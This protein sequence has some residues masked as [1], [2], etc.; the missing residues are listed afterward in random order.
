MQLRGIHHLTAVTGRA[1]VNHDFYTRVM[2]MRLVKKTVNQDDVSAY[3]LFYADGVAQPG[4]DLTFFDWPVGPERRGTNSIVRTALRVA[5]AAALEYWAAR[6]DQLGVRHDPIAAVDGR[7][8]LAFEDT[9]GQRLALVVDG[10]QGPAFAW[11]RTEVP[12]AQQIRGLGPIIISVPRLPPSERF[13]TDILNMR[14][15]RAYAA[16]D[17]AAITTHVFEMDQGGPSAEL[18]VR[19]EPGLRPAQPGAGGVHHVAFRVRDDEYAAWVARYEQLGVRSSGP[20]DRF[21]F[22]SLYAREPGGVLYEIAT[23]GPGFATD[24]SLETLGESLSLPPFL[25]SRRAEIERGL[26]PL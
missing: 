22:R 12:P 17:D 24:E 14:L 18:N 5:D 16:A 4:T 6:F 7:Q 26:K 21:Y 15:V 25:E 8:Q 19:V 1:G 13:L 2:G 23:D 11:D 3:H 9:E 10:G 20:V